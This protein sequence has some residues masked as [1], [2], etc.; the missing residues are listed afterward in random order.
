MKL[1]RMLQIIHHNEADM[2]V[3]K[4]TQ[5][6]AEILY[7]FYLMFCWPCTVIYPYN[8]NQ[9]DALFTFNLSQ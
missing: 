4:E 3:T 5:K 8:K 9:Q 1:I 2:D 6:K 7:I